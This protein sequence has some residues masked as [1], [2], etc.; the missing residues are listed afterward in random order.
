MLVLDAGAFVSAERGKGDVAALVKNE[1]ASGRVPLTNGAV[2]AQVW[3]GGNG[4]QVP[5]A[6]L[7]DNVEVVPVD[8]VL[9][10]RA[11]MLLART[12]AADA[13]DASVVCLAQDGDDILTSDPGDLLDLV[14]ATGVHV[15]LIPV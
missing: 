5:V 1:F 8:D 14:R 3:R 2:I 6:R 11:G 15:E 4:R 9:G 7:L 10:K 13:I 12:G